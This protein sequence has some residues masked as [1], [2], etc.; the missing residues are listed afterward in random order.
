MGAPCTLGGLLLS[1]LQLLAP[2]RPPKVCGCT[3]AVLASTDPM[4]FFWGGLWWFLGRVA[5]VWGFRDPFSGPFFF[6]NS[7]EG[8]FEG[9][10][11]ENH[12]FSGRLP[13]GHTHV[14]PG[15]FKPWVMLIVGCPRLVVVQ[16]TGGGNT[17]LSMEL[18]STC[19]PSTTRSPGSVL[20]HFFGGGLPY[21]NRLQKKGTLILT[22]LLED[23]NNFHG[24]IQFRG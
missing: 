15:F 2:C 7:F 5:Y 3:S 9:K 4:F 16:T 14:Q 19:F 18:G 24:A 11:K 13:F 12:Q 10:P 8:W 23:L 22:S 20:L 21:E 6:C 1:R 17:S